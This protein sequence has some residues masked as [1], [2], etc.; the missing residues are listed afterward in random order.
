[1]TI[2]IVLPQDND[3]VMCCMGTKVFCGDTEIHDVTSIK[4][5]IN[6]DLILCAKIEVAI[7]SIENMDNIHA[8]LGTKTLEQ[9]ALLHGCKIE[10]QEIL[11]SR[12][13]LQVEC[14]EFIQDLK[15]KLDSDKNEG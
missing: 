15:V 13:G 2:K 1:M 8:L 7:S 12:T 3:D 9:I 6:P 5:D 10:K 4:I 11:E 14:D